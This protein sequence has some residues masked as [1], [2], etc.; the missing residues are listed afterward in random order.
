MRVYVCERKRKRV[1]VN[2]RMCADM[3]IVWLIFWNAV[4]V[5][6]VVTDFAATS[7]AQEA[8]YWKVVFAGSHSTGLSI[9][10]HGLPVTR[11]FFICVAMGQNT[12]KIYSFNFSNAYAQLNWINIESEAKIYLKE[13]KPFQL[14]FPI[15]WIK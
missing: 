10:L 11:H 5:D 4:N 8:N 7:L 13:I 3:S 6:Y 12:Q 1:S 14:S 2:E 9:K 15:I